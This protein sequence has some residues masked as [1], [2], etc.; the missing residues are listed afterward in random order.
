VLAVGVASAL[1]IAW[2]LLSNEENES[3]ARDTNVISAVCENTENKCS[4][5]KEN[6]P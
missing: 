4:T 5:Q 6:S 1:T 2:V 3:C